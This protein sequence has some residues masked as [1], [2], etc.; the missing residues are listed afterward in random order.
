MMTD[1]GKRAVLTLIVSITLVFSG[2]GCKGEK[3]PEPKPETAPPAPKTVQRVLFAGTFYPS[4]PAQLKKMIAGYLEKAEPTPVEG[5]LFGF[6]VPHAG[7][8][9]S[10]RTAAYAYKLIAASGIKRFV[11]IGPSHRDNF[12]GVFVLD[13][14]LY[15]TPLGEVAID[16]E[17]AKKISGSHPWIT[18]N[19]WVY[20]REHSIEVQIPFLQETVV[21]GL[22]INVI[23]IGR[24]KYPEVIELA[25]VLEEVFPED[26]HIFLASSD[27]THG[28]YPPYKGTDAIKPIDLRT[29][30]YISKMDILAIKEGISTMRTPLCGGLP[31]LTLMNLFQMRGG[32]KAVTLHYSDSGDATGD[33]SKVVGYGVSAFVLPAGDD[34]G[35]KASPPEPELRSALAGSYTLSEDEKK[36]LLRMARAC[37]TAAVKKEPIP[38]MDTEF[39][40]LKEQGAAFVTLKTRGNLRG[41]IGT[42]VPTEPLYLC[43]QRRAVDA[44]IHDSRFAFNPI[45]PDELYDIEIEISVLTPTKRASGPSDIEVGTDGVLLTLGQNRGV[46]LPQVP[47]EQGWDREAYLSNLCRKAGV[48]DHDCYKRPEAILDKFQ[49]IVFSESE[50]GIHPESL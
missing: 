39:P 50:L 13:K 32:Q 12:E 36:E 20:A 17:A 28:N 8:V 25:R 49:A 40:I 7:Y 26:D 41:C 9:Y 21:E 10:G 22:V 15:R 30:D 31:V 19:P 24:V 2:S 37:V 42:I 33:H 47:V 23:M 16:R 27:M 34:G 45:R 35:A 44:A 3:K 14:D 1:R 18:T 5:R 46:F 43:V 4:D 48:D 11:I 38:G 6:M 29:L